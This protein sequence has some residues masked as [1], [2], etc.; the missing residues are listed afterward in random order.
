MRM[1]AG[2]GRP[3][4]RA[5]I[6]VMLPWPYGPAKMLRRSRSHGREREACSG[7]AAGRG[8]HRL[9]HPPDR[10]RARDAPAAGD[11]LGCDPHHLV[12][13]MAVPWVGHRHPRPR[14]RRVRTAAACGRQLAAAQG[15]RAQEQDV[16]FPA[17]GAGTLPPRRGRWTSGIAG[18]TIMAPGRSP[19]GLPGSPIDPAWMPTE[20]LGNSRPRGLVLQPARPVRPRGRRFRRWSTRAT[21]SG[22]RPT[23]AMTTTRP[24]GRSRRK[25][26]KASRSTG[27]SARTRITAGTTP[28]PSRSRMLSRSSTSKATAFSREPRRSGGR[29]WIY[30]SGWNANAPEQC[31]GAAV[32]LHDAVLLRA[33]AHAHHEGV[34][35]E[36][37]H[38]H[39][40]VG[41]TAEG[42]EA[43]IEL[44]ELRVALRML[45]IHLVGC[46]VA[47]LQDGFGEGAQ[48]RAAGNETL[49]G[50]RVAMVVLPQ[51]PLPR[52]AR[53]GGDGR[54]V[55]FRQLVPLGEV[56]QVVA[57]AAA[58]PPAGVVVVL[59]DLVEAELLVVV[60]ADPFARVERA[61]LQRRI[62]VATGQLLRH[63][64]DPGENGAGEAANPE[65]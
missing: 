54:L 10:V 21:A 12:G 50:G 8:H 9:L 26:L 33:G 51:H 56:D 20:C 23:E 59:G 6:A 30:R 13:A 45:S 55:G 4:C 61:L 31:S 11:Q 22:R 39:P 32:C 37:R 41:I 36:L 58:F 16:I 34:V 53:S 5:R 49:E 35:A 29:R 52:F 60:G 25:A 46:L 18:A 28:S 48:Q 40:L 47:G 17:P 7:E 44:L 62:D 19:H 27:S 63:D 15:R 42:N 2:G 1:R 64:A 3:P 14:P 24:P 57:L 43:V 38:L 65:L